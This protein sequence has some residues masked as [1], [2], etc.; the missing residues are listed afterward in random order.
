MSTVLLRKGPPSAARSKGYLTNL[1][2]R[3]RP[4]AVGIAQ[5]RRLDDLGYG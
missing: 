2:E 5:S 1:R 3:I 4:L